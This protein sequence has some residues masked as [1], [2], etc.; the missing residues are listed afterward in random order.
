[1]ESI[2]VPVLGI[3]ENMAYFS[4]KELPDNKYYIFGKEGAKQ[5]SEEME[6]ELLAEIPIFQSLRE[7]A[8]AGRPAILQGATPIA[9]QLL[10]M[11]KNIVRS[12]KKRNINLAPTKAVPLTNS[13]GCK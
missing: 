13:K 1:M 7:A 10:T 2:N 12:I 9:L 11:T 8:D 6:I 4:P 3:V 5:L